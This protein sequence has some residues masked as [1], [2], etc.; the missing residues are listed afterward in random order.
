MSHTTVHIC[1]V[2]SCGTDAGD[3]AQ[4]RTQLENK[5]SSLPLVE[6]RCFVMLLLLHSGF[7]LSDWPN[8]TY[9][10]AKK[11]LDGAHFF[12]VRAT[13]KIKTVLY[14]KNPPKKFIGGVKVV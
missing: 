10:V 2:L 5:L 4:S 9:F 3:L 1:P 6:R 12:L 8:W 13:M 7:A 14:Q 11:T